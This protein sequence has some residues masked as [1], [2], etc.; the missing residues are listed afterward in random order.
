M[1]SLSNGRCEV[2]SRSGEV[3]ALGSL[4]AHPRLLFWGDL[5]REGLRIALALRRNLPTLS[6]SALYAPMCALVNQRE[7]SHPYL[8]MSGKALQA[9][10]VRTGDE[11]LDKLADCCEDRA[12]D[13][14]ALDISQHRDLAA[15]ALSQAAFG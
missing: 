7:T 1:D 3:H 4:F 14:E 6:L 8:D 15:K 11:L 10:W 13:Q 9:P 12:V 2:L 5:D